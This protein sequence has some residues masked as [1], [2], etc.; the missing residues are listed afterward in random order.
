MFSNVSRLA[1]EK[2]LIPL[3]TLIS[4]WPKG[5]KR[6]KI[7]MVGR[8]EEEE[9]LYTQEDHGGIRNRKVSFLSS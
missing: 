5:A 2:M 9:G 3:D 1:R 8:G 6:L 4:W 7:V